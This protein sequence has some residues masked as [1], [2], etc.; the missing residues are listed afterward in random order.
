MS[1]I[2]PQGTE[3]HKEKTFHVIHSTYIYKLLW[4][5]VPK[6]NKEHF[7]TLSSK[8]L[9]KIKYT[10][11]RQEMYSKGPWVVDG[12]HQTSTELTIDF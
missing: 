4:R 8:E 1:L 12:T 6:P 10:P 2:Y 7:Y 5:K 3:L 9:I 11:L